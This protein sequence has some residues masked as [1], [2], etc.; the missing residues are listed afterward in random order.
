MSNKRSAPIKRI[1][2][3][4][5]SNVW[6]ENFIGARVRYSDRWTNRL[7]KDLRGKARVIADGLPGRVAGEFRTD[8]PHKNGK[9]TFAKSLSDAGPLDLIIVALG[10]NDLQQ[11]F[12]RTASDIIDDLLSY[13]TTSLVPIVY[14]LPPNFQVDASPEFTETSEKLRQELLRH[15]NELGGSI[16]LPKLPLSDGIHFSPQGQR[17]VPNIVRKMLRL[18]MEL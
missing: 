10:T 1:L 16:E 2:I 5:D 14:I 3:Y 7:R 11:R 12:E 15:Q 8:K 4:G 13:K 18:Y 9:A 17:Q 6:G